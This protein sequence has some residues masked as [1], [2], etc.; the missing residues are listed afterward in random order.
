MSELFCFFLT[1]CRVTNALIPA[2]PIH[3]FWMSLYDNLFLKKEREQ[4]HMPTLKK[5][6]ASL[7]LLGLAASGA[8]AQIVI[9]YY[10]FMQRRRL[11]L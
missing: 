2:V 11:D 10:K 4:N 9:T 5:T 6:A 1:Q 8:H 7:T 3:V